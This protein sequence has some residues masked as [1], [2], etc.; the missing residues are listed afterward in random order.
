MWLG[1]RYRQHHTTSKGEATEVHRTI[2]PQ[3]LHHTGKGENISEAMSGD[4]IYQKR[5]WIIYDI[6]TDM[7]F[8]VR[9]RA[10]AARWTRFLGTAPSCLPG[11]G[12]HKM[13]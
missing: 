7:V 6:Y 1:C 9:S 8:T 2:H 11:R 3:G 4:V 12:A 10:R 5:F 13:I